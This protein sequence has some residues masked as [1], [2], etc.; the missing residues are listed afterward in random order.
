MQCSGKSEIKFLL[1]CPRKNYFR[2]NCVEIILTYNFG[3]VILAPSKGISV[4][5]GMVGVGGLVGRQGP[6][7]G[8]PL[9]L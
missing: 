5:G 4:L 6:S 1:E 8:H 7:I 3:M 9:R 2:E